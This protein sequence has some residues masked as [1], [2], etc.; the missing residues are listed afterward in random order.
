M[1]MAAA[2]SIAPAG[3]NHRD[4]IAFVLSGGSSLGAVQVGMLQ[5]LLESGIRPDLLVGTSVGAIDLAA[6]IDIRRL[7]WCLRSRG[8]SPGVPR[9]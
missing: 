3:R 5:A 8:A 1:S 6:A 2:R 4:R 9:A 7:A